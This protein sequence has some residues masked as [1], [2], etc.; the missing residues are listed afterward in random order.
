MPLLVQDNPLTIRSLRDDEV[1]RL[2][3]IY[4]DLPIS[5]KHCPTCKGVGSFR[6][7]DSDG[8]PADW[9][10]NCR[11]QWALHRFFL[12]SGIGLRYQRLSWDDTLSVA[13][14]AK[15]AVIEYGAEADALVQIGQGLILHGKAMGTGKTLLAS[16]L[17]KNLLA[18]G[19]DGYF[20]QFNEMLD[21]FTG[22]WRNEEERRWFNRR[23]R[24]AG[25][26]V[27]DDVGRE[28]KGR[29]EVAESMFDTV[30]RARHDDAR[31]TIITT[32]LSLDDLRSGY[33]SNVMSLLSGV[34]YDH[35][36]TGLDYRPTA[37]TEQA[38][39]VR[40]GLTRPLVI[41]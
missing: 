3:A 10:C 9:E 5:P 7:R 36:V 16:L 37:R 21:A 13:A 20:V 39:E 33:S 4:P 2:R 24:N 14:P 31:P 26:L 28:H 12:N 35:E 40:D 30:I 25:V 41:G 1:A 18:S 22:G 15:K 6:W 19:Y 29:L 32:N 8:Q 17:L 11:A 27:V 23:V 38:Q 34:C